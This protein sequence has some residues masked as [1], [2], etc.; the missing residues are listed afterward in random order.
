LLSKQVNYAKGFPQQIC[1]LANPALLIGGT[2]SHVERGCA[3][4]T[5]QARG[6]M[7]MMRGIIGWLICILGTLS[8][9]LYASAHVASPDSGSAAPCGSLINWKSVQ[10]PTAPPVPGGGDATVQG[11]SYRLY[12]RTYESKIVDT[13]PVLVVVLHGD[14]PPPY[15][16]PDYQY[17]F[18]SKAAAENRNVVA[19]GL[20]RPGYT[21][22]QGHHSQG[23]SGQRDGDNWGV[24]DTDAIADAIAA[25]KRRYKAREVVVAGHSGG[26]A[27]AANILGRHPKLIDAALL[28]SC[29]CG[30]VNR[31]RADMLRH[32]GFSVFEGNIQSLSPIDQVLGIDLRTSIVMMTGTEDHVAPLAIAERYRAAA[33]GAG[34]DVTLIKLPGRPHNTFIYPPVFAELDAIIRRVQRQGVRN[35]QGAVTSTTPGIANLP[36]LNR[37]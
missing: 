20:L 3:F 32:T 6:A 33:A 15:Q 9:P 29:P 19:V 4:R 23:C 21:D 30:D 36:H 12:A 24:R 31:W 5:N 10:F 25:L 26:A 2:A 7:Q 18:A 1:E 37:R 35:T 34:K 28:V 13:H 16:F 14:G 8:L 11:G 27:I 17:V 22:P